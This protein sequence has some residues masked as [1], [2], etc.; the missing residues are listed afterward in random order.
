M[1]TNIANDEVNKNNDND[2]NDNDNNNKD[3]D[4][5]TNNCERTLQLDSPS[6]DESDNK[7]SQNLLEE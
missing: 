3:N 6:S 1:A 2:N 5:D 7:L 4:I